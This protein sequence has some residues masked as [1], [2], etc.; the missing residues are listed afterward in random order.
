MFFFTL[1][2]NAFYVRVCGWAVFHKGPHTKQGK[3][4]QSSRTCCPVSALGAA[5]P[6]SARHR[7]A[8]CVYVRFICLFIVI[9]GLTTTCLGLEDPSTPLLH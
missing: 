2:D 4:D 7:A 8:H 1:H 5:I 6:Q 9:E 3:L